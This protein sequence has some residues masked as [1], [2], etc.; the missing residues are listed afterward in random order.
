MKNG[1]QPYILNAAS[2]LMGICFILIAG[3]KITH[4]E[5]ATFADEISTFAAILFMAS[6]VLSYLSLRHE[7]KA[8]KL[9]N[10]ADRLF[11]GGMLSLFVAVIV[12]A[13]NIL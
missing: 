9:E 8:E 2:N 4:S 1:K 5:I 13:N 3:L 11:L 10:I 12:F 6:C 7:S